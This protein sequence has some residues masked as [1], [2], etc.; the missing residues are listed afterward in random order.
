MEI[1]QDNKTLR[2]ALATLLGTSAVALT[3]YFFFL[4]NQA[5]TRNLND[6]QEI[7][8]NKP[9]QKVIEE[10]KRRVNS[11][12]KSRGSVLNETDMTKVFGALYIRLKTKL[13]PVIAMNTQNRRKVRSKDFG[14]YLQIVNFQVEQVN[15]LVDKELGVILKDI[16]CSDELFSRSAQKH[17]NLFQ[18]QIKGILVHV[19]SEALQNLH[20]EKNKKRENG[21]WKP[22]ELDRFVVKDCLD[23]L[24]AE[25]K[26]NGS[27]FKG[28]ENPEKVAVNWISD[29]LYSEH[30]IEYSR[31][32][33]YLNSLPDG[34]EAKETLMA[35]LSDFVNLVKQ[36]GQG[37][38]N[39]DG[40]SEEEKDS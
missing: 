14:K 17:Q 11:L 6:Y 5:Q 27:Y 25:I 19:E 1:A 3:A 20:K 12:S 2:I 15:F 21:E 34:I 40:G 23:Y 28:I 16:N 9:Y 35:K 29:S 32:I 24:I 33:L 22:K 13:S 38:D 4:R 18:K 8:G 39:D 30:E 31:M 26:K 36:A 10:I 7:V 37:L